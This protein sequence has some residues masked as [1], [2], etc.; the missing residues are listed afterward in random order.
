M[1]VAGGHNGAGSAGH[2]R[3][4]DGRRADAD[5]VGRANTNQVQT[6]LRSGA[7]VRRAECPAKAPA[8]DVWRREDLRTVI[9]FGE[10]C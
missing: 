8:A 9:E 1:I 4:D 3:G 10:G 6:G 5:P 7:Y 2:R